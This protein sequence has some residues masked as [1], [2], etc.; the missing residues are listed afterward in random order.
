M[1]IRIGIGKLKISQQHFGG[2][3]SWSSY[4]TQ[5]NILQKLDF[6][7]DATD[8]YL[9]DVSG[10]GNNAQLVNSNCTADNSNASNTTISSTLAVDN[11]L[12][13]DF[14]VEFSFVAYGSGAYRG[15]FGRSASGTFNYWL[16]LFM[17]FNDDNLIY[18]SGSGAANSQVVMCATVVGTAYNVKASVSNSTG[19]IDWIINGVA[20][21]ANFTNR[22]PATEGASEIVAIGKMVTTSWPFYGKRWGF[23]Y[24]TSVN[25]A[26]LTHYWPIAEGNGNIMYDV[27][28]TKHLTGDGTIL[29]STQDLLHYNLIY[30]FELYGNSSATSQLIRVPIQ[31][32]G[33][34]LTPVIAGYTKFSDCEA[35]VFHNFAETGIKRNYNNVAALTSAGIANTNIVY[36]GGV[37]GSSGYAFCKNHLGLETEYTVYSEAELLTTYRRVYFGNTAFSH[38]M[39]DTA[40]KTLIV[41]TTGKIHNT[42][43]KTIIE[44]TVSTGVYYNTFIRNGNYSITDAALMNF[45]IPNGCR[46]IGESKAGVVITAELAAATLKAT[47]AATSVFNNTNSTG[48]YRVA[49]ITATCK[50]M[51]YVFHDDKD[52]DN[53]IKRL[54]NVSFKHLGNHAAYLLDNTIWNT[55]DAM[56]CGNYD[57][58]D[59]L[60]TGCDFEGIKQDG[61]LGRGF[62]SH[63]KAD[64]ATA[65]GVLKFTSCSFKTGGT[66]A[67]SFRFSPYQTGQDDRCEFRGCNFNGYNI[68]VD[69]FRSYHSTADLIH[70]YKNVAD[71]APTIISDSHFLIGLKITSGSSNTLTVN[72]GTVRTLLLGIEKTL[73]DYS[74]VGRVNIVSSGSFA[75]E[76]ALAGL[77]GDCTG[78]SKVLSVK[79]NGVDTDIEMDQDYSAMTNA[80]VLTSINGINADVQFS[81]YDYGTNAAFI[82]L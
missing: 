33:T 71:S 27:V 74:L 76:P 56:G 2:G 65:P 46:V 11:M 22:T 51:R 18:I 32:D 49:N 8:R 20:G 25:Y 57:G 10:Q 47:I 21:G 67:N 37:T 26:N 30:G 61:G 54:D 1:S 16:S 23:K 35:G 78:T 14:S 17:L 42:V 73:N 59:L 55:T 39:D 12:F 4:W 52:V 15:L 31:L 81:E 36:Y 64:T 80:Q 3:E 43:I 79:L 24:Y 45:V 28:G 5:Q 29:W 7:R 70:L 68:L 75:G 66:G 53:S 13:Y 60:I 77:L 82:N 62:A 34:K 9:L 69:I 58:L 6:T 63:G 38:Y 48:N 40:T 41:G 72:V 50:N 19:R 44:Q